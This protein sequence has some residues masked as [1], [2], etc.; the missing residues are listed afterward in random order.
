[1]PRYFV[2]MPSKQRPDFDPTAQATLI[3]YSTA[4]SFE[5]TLKGNYHA[6]KQQ[7]S[8]AEMNTLTPRPR[9]KAKGHHRFKAYV[10]AKKILVR[11]AING[12]QDHHMLYCS[13]CPVP[14]LNQDVVL[15]GDAHT[16]GTWKRKWDNTTNTFALDHIALHHPGVPL[17]QTDEDA[18]RVRKTL[19][20]S[21]NSS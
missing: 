9:I 19:Y 3:D 4:K 11:K 7:D 18:A 17:F 6:I 15:D 10:Y 2:K 12:D 13:H 1:M 8:A 5:A 20:P 21:G 14:D 16:R